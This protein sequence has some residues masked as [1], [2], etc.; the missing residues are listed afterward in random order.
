M[1]PS[2]HVTTQGGRL[3][4]Q[5]VFICLKRFMAN[6]YSFIEKEFSQASR[7]PCSHCS[8]DDS[9][10]IRLHQCLTLRKTKE[11]NCVTRGLQ[12]TTPYIPSKYNV[13]GLCQLH[14]L[15]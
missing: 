13:V 2:P 3:G 15:P 1:V 14:P 9:S 5:E 10:I 8:L 12:P 6:D 11:Y 4:Q 7:A